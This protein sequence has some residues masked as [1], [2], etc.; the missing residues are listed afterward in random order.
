MGWQFGEVSRILWTG[1]TL[2]VNGAADRINLLPSASF[3][4]SGKPVRQALPFERLDYEVDK[5]PRFR[6]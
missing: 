4:A 2:R 6:R 5:H 3:D 1:L